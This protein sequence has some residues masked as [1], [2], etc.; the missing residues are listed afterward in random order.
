MRTTLVDAYL[1]EYNYGW[2]VFCYVDDE[3]VQKL[4]F[5]NPDDAHEAAQLWEQTVETA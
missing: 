1:T 3:C 2:A 4:C 5:N